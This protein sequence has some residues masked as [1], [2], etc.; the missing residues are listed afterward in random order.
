MANLYVFFDKRSPRKD[1]TGTLKLAI[2][3]KH[4]TVY[5]S[6]G[7]RVK[8][9]EWDGPHCQV[10]NRLDKKFHNVVITKRMLEAQEALTRIEQRRDFPKLTARDL[11]DMIMRGTDTADTPEDGDY[12]LPVYNEYITLCRKPNT[13]MS[14]KYSLRNLKE[15][16][17]GIDTLTFKDINVAWLR[18]YQ[19]WMLTA[20]GMA[21]NGANVYLRNLRTVFNYALQNE[22]TAAHY[23]FKSID[24][25]TTEPDKRVIPY[26]KFLE[27][28]TFPVSDRREMYRD[29]FMLSFY[30]CGIRPVDLLNVRKNQVEDGRLVYYPEKL[31]GRTK[32]SIKIEPEAWEIIHKYEGSEYLIN[33]MDER[34]DYREFCKHWNKALKAIGEDEDVERVGRRGKHYTKTVHHGIVPYI[35]IYY[36]RTCWATFGYNVCELSMD[37]ISQALGHKSGLRVTN[38]YVKRD[39]DRVDKANRQL[40]DR[41]LGDMREYETKKGQ[42]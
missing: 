6:L 27:W 8:P 16:E 36:A 23:P 21:V 1:G 37:T 5:E 13:S 20:K 24:M 14:Y 42:P 41:V 31:G 38:F 40:L 19:Q 26:K 10:V 22:L 25:S 30:L 11:L 15:F 4:K 39:T 18:K 34:T 35:T 33:I 7:I 28:A 12:V 3:H 29:L 17:P 9:D 2:T 32:L